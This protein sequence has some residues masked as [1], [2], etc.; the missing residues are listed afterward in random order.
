MRGSPTKW[1]PP[2]V[3]AIG[4]VVS[5][6]LLAAAFPPFALGPLAFVALIPVVVCLYRG[7]YSHRAFFNTGYLFGVAFFGGLLWWVVK[8]SPAASMTV[9]WLLVPATVVLVLYLAVYPGL[10]FLSLRWI[11]RGRKLFAVLLAPALWA[12]VERLRGSGEFG[13]PWGSIGYSL[14]HNPAMMQSASYVGVLGLGALVVFVNM[15]LAGAR[16]ARSAV[17]RMAF[18][19]AGIGVFA[20]NFYGGKLAIERF[21]GRKP[22]E[23]RVVAL[24]QPNVDLAIKWKPEYADSLF[25]QILRMTREA[26][27]FDPGLIVFPE[28]AAPVYMRHSREHT[29]MMSALARDLETSVFIGF[30]DARYDGPGGALNLYNSSGLFLPDGSTLQYDKIHLLPFGEAIPYAWKFR[31]LQHIDFGQANFLPGPDRLPL[32]SPVGDLA[33]LVCFESTFSDLPRRAVLR[34]ADLLVNITNDGWFGNTPGP[35]QHSDMA[36]LRA[37][38]NRR[39]LARSGNTGVTMIVDPVGRVT[40]RLAMDREGILAGDIHAVGGTAFY[41][42]QGDRPVII[43]SLAILVIGLLTGFVLSSASSRTER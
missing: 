9:P 16:L 32:A 19:A 26:A 2:V 31:V 20:L 3:P 34:G 1:F 37:V 18:L 15:L 40:R 10:F 39:F 6:L 33:P 41:T 14:V 4:A 7:S 8:L 36:I 28:T 38:E 21:D 29:K 12:L 43:A 30:L 23:R 42:R 22:G 35:Y 13:F 5:G 24:A 11:G 25:N 27:A 17:G